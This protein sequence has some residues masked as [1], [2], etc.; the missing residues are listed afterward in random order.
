[1]SEILVVDDDGDLRETVQMLLEDAGFTV[2]GARDGAEALTL[3]ASA[4]VLPGLIL[5]D[6]AMPVMNGSEFRNHQRSD[7]RLADIPV[8]VM[9]ASGR[10]EVATPAMAVAATLAKPFT[11]DALLA[12][13]RRFLRA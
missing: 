13:A 5:L 2:G 11:P 1:M 7:A 12:L 10:I 4:P 8:I 3:L 6:L 9:S